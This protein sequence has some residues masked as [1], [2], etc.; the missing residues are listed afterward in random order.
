MRTVQRARK[1]YYNPINDRFVNEDILTGN[2]RKLLSHNMYAYC[3]GNPVM[4]ADSSGRQATCTLY[5]ILQAAGAMAERCFNNLISTSKKVVEKFKDISEKYKDATGGKSLMMDIAQ[6]I[7]YREGMKIVDFSITSRLL[8]NSVMH[9]ALST[10]SDYFG[11]PGVSS[12]I[13]YYVDTVPGLQGWGS[14]VDPAITWTAVR[15]GA[16]AG[17]FDS[18][19]HMQYNV[20]MNI[21]Y[22]DDS[23]LYIS[24]TFAEGAYFNGLSIF[25]AYGNSFGIGIVSSEVA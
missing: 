3:S 6:R 19:K 15:C 20:E 21:L 10:I 17:A 1:S 2:G 5:D 7:P 12:Q 25:S 4:L 13:G 16:W 22:P 23:T 18:G 24:F 9:I 8:P 11:F 14:I